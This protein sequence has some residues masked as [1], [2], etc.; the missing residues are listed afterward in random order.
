MAL[1]SETAAGYT[2][3]SST[4]VTNFT[5]IDSITS[6]AGG[7]LTS[8]LGSATTWTITGANTGDVAVGA[9]QFG[10]T[11]FS[12]LNADS[13]GDAFV[14]QAGS[15]ESSIN[16]GT[17]S[18]SIDLSALASAATVALASET[19]AGY[20]GTSRTG[21]TNF[22]N[23]DSI[24]SKAGGTLTSNLGSATT[25]TITG[26]NTGDVAVGAQ[27]F[28]YTNFSTL[29]AD[30]HGD[31]FVFQA[32][33]SESSIN[34]GTGS[35]SIN[36]S[37]LAAA[38][39]VQLNSETAAGY[40]GTS[41]TGVANFTNIDSIT[42][43]AGGTLTSNLGSATTWTITGANT[44]DVAVGAQQFGY[45]NFSTLNADAN[46]DAFT[47]HVGGSES[48]ING[49]T[50]SDSI[51]LSALAAATVTLASETA[52]GYTGTSSTG[53]T[54]FTDID[55]ITAKD[56]ST[57]TSAFAGAV[58]W[59]ITGGDIGNV[60]VGAQ[61]FDF[62]N[63]GSLNGGAGDDSFVVA[64]GGSLTGAINGGG[65]TTQNTLSYLGYVGLVS[66]QV[67]ATGTGTSIAGGFS[68]IQ[69][70]VGNDGILGTSFTLVGDTFGDTFALSA[71]NQGTLTYGSG[72]S[73]SLTFSGVGNLQGNTGADI[74]DL[75][76]VGRGP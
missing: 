40:T 72:G 1:A 30:S 51:D 60:L 75:T 70:L 69:N 28:G 46:G 49:G 14:F 57:L 15:S 64:T 36:L 6:K 13:H 58:T 29:N 23:I 2:G 25:W 21:V 17:G 52:A 50:G 56:P 22:T 55:S 59:T 42:S 67:G 71:I 20:T 24:T 26:A 9:Q 16:G 61:Q 73:G 10:Y 44:G 11:N 34:G 74:L 12:T 53:V 63:F 18:D 54:N 39:T 7:T 45:T 66:V 62:T 68:N 76:G 19:A 27:Q 38:A 33:S 3:T 31:A 35:D 48:S 4:G 8:N 65:F 5:N 41:S 37:A 32:G 47:F 43:K